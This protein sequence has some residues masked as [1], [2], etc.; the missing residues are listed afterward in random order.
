[1][2]FNLK[3]DKYNNI[4]EVRII[5]YIISTFIEKEKE[6]EL[7]ESRFEEVKKLVKHS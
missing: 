6:R 3:L 5:Y 4:Q 7:A 1:M 2:I